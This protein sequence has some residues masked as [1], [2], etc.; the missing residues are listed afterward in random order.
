[1]Y[2]KLIYYNFDNL[3]EKIN[4]EK[5]KVKKN[6]IFESD[7]KIIGCTRVYDQSQKTNIYSKKD[8]FLNL[9]DYGLIL[10]GDHTRVIKF[11]KGACL[12]SDEGVVV[13]KSK[14]NNE[15]FYFYLLQSLKIK[16]L[17]YSRH[18]K[19]IRK[20]NFAFTPDTNEQIKIS[21]F[22]SLLDKHIEL[23]ER[24]LQFTKL[25][26]SWFIN[27]V[28]R[29]SP[30]SEVNFLE[31]FDYYDI[32]NKNFE[33]YTIGKKGIIK[34]NTIKETKENGR[35]F[36]KNSIIFGLGSNEIGVSID[37][38][39]SCSPIY[40]TY[41]IKDN[42]YTKYF[43]YFSNYIFKEKENYFCK[44]STRREKEI[45]RKLLEKIK[46]KL[47]DFD[48]LWKMEILDFFTKEITFLDKQIIL[49]KKQRKFYLNKLFI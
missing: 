40:L 37:K 35:A 1:F 38:I 31:L 26:K 41:K 14:N 20:Y 42:I 23:W 25:K 47:I 30:F 43:F 11:L 6:E 34:M 21:K 19:L 3:F 48:S 18:F 10:F 28:W 22:F 44:K 5:H 49:L 45:S 2:Q 16:N 32:Q 13:L 33:K 29:N 12:F 7:K 39:G 8:N 4:I 27:F 36:Y 24:K 46:I 9:I 15:K 17:G